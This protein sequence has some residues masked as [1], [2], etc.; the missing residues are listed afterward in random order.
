MEQDANQDAAEDV[1]KDE[2]K[3]A[4]KDE[5]DGASKDEA[6]DAGKDE[7]T[8]ASKNEAKDEAK[9]ASKDVKEV[10]PKKYRFASSENPDLF[11]DGAYPDDEAA[12]L[13]A[14]MCVEIWKYPAVKV[15]QQQEDE[16]WSDV[17]MVYSDRIESLT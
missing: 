6:K 11:A 16:S 8:D 17:A 3:D 9:D 5:A 14:K 12:M 4:N 7:A 10:K 15:T 2:A 13:I 1:S